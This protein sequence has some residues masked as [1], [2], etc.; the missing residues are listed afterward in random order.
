MGEVFKVAIIGSG[1]A[2]MSAAS[3]AAQ[4]GLS[5]VLLEKTD[6]LSDTIYKYQKGK[7]VMATPS[8]LILRSD[9]EFDAGKKEDILGRWNER[10]AELGV[11]VKYNAEVK[12]IRGTGPAIPGSVQ[13]I[14]SRARDGSTTTTELQRHAPPYAIELT[15]GETVM[16]QNVVLAIGTQGNPNLMR[17]PGGD[18]PHVTY[19]L[20]DPYAVL[21][22]HIVV[23][24]T[25]DAGIENARGLV[26]DP[27]Q[28]NVVTVLNRSPKST[29][30]RESFATAKEPN[31]KALIEDDAAGKL[32]IRYETETKAVEPG[33][34]TLSTRDGEE[35]IR[36]D[37]IIARIGSAPPRAFVEGCGIEFASADRL[38]FPT[39][40]PQF[41]STA[42]GI[43]VIGALAG[44]PLIKHCM[45]Q[46][47]DVV[48]FI[49][50]NTDLKPADEPLLEAKFAGLPGNRSVNEWLEFLRSNVS[51]LEGMTTLQLREFMLDSE[52]RAY[53][54]GDVV[55]EKN[56]PGSSLFAI[57]SGSVH[58]R[59]DPKD[60]SKVI[61]I[62]AGTIFGEV[63]LISGRRRGATI[64]A[65]E[66]AVCVEIS[67]NAALKLQSQVPTAKRTIERISTERQILQMFGS[68]LTSA[69]IAEVVETSKIVQVRAG[70]AIIKE[71]DEDK[72]I[73]VIRVGSMI[74][75]K[76]VGGKPVF[77]SY[78]PAG[79]YVGEMALIDGGR[80]T[81]TVRAA[82]K[83]EVI[84]ID[85]DAFGRV[86]AAKPALL[87][88]AR[89]DMEVRR[90]TNAFIESKKDSFSGVVDL[91]SEQAKFLVAQGLGEATDVLLIDERLC[92]GCDNCE[93]ACADSHDGLSR[94][95]R[96][97]GKS[98]AHLHVP[99]SCRH[100]EHP[101]C[102]ADCPPN[103]IHRGPD[104]EVFINDTC[105]GCGNCQRNCPYGV[106]RMDKVPPKKPSLLSWLFFGRGPGPGEPP[107]KWS[108]K[109]TKYTGDPAVDELLDRKKAI[110]C[111]MCAGIEG[112]PSC[113]RACPTG[114]AIRV[115][116]DEFLTVARLENE[117]A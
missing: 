104:G 10:T 28:G 4:L 111:D 46:G 20:D 92:V 66:D 108:K 57:A 73:Y 39:L 67:R 31:A 115:S 93:K 35:R 89:K 25:G 51:I 9:Q 69:D 86:L 13:K 109:N 107:Y 91:Y 11:N 80:R 23:V 40:S 97:A 34:I 77:L 76:E 48:E 84:R 75:E 43:F 83:S 70:D 47:Y 19:Q 52:A 21:D 96:E 59:L 2:G 55:F 27:A 16:A 5:H 110:K 60:P 72:D 63:G 42:P 37:R 90:A 99:T 24:G 38:A 100:C 102:M 98:F 78:L 7:H 85:G 33:W 29:N 14:V 32:T 65:A 79:S 113:V 50:G 105:I 41:E 56:D 82:I 26:E 58:V 1:P 71:G 22:Q 94:L 6:H 62:P 49:N 81:A 88:R 54:K 95:D 18:L 103:A 15:N 106:I 68:G 8:Q 87:D 53:R 114:A 101:H 117:G 30:V 12:A 3:R 116:P 36:C 74:V 17:C 112:G 64:V 45:N 44:Y 61:P